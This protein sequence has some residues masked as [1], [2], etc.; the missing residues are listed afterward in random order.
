MTLPATS[1][2]WMYISI[3]CASGFLKNAIPS[4]SEPSAGWGTVWRWLHEDGT[5]G[6]GGC[7]G[8]VLAAPAGR[9]GYWGLFSDGVAVPH[10]RPCSSPFPAGSW[11]LRLDQ[12]QAKSLAP[13]ARAL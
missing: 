4:A 13:L 5:G 6:A 7:D 11:L 12:F 8:S 3:G 9:N 2:P 10:H 1:A